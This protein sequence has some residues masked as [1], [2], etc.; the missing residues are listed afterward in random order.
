M[1]AVLRDD[2]Y[3]RPLAFDYENDA[4]AAKVEDQLLLGSSIMIAP[5]YEQNAEGRY[6]YLPET[7]KMVKFRSLTE[8]TEE[9]IAAGHHYI[10]IALDEVAIFIRPNQILPLSKG[11][12]CVADVDFTELELLGYVTEEAVY[13]LYDDDG[14]GKDYENPDNYTVFTMKADGS[15]EKLRNTML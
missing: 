11:G 14:Y 3:F 15:T 5:V 13:E 8:R 6:V 4:F 12:E 2:L 1:K 7:M 9:I 10:P